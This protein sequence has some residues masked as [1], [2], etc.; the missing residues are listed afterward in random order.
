MSASEP[1]RGPEKLINRI[2]LGGWDEAL[3]GPRRGEF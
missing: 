2:F 1:S 3:E